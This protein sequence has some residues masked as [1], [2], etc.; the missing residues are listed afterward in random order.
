MLFVFDLPQY[1]HQPVII[2]HHVFVIVFEQNPSVTFVVQDGLG[3][4]RWWFTTD[5]SEELRLRSTIRAA[6]L[7]HHTFCTIH[8]ILSVAH[9]LSGTET[10]CRQRARLPAHQIGRNSCPLSFRYDVMLIIVPQGTIVTYVGVELALLVL[11]AV[12]SFHPNGLFVASSVLKF[13]TAIL[14]ITLSIVDH[15]RSP[16]PSVLLSS[17]LFVTLILDVAQVRTL[18]L[19]AGG[20]SERTYSSLFSASVALKVAM[21]LLEAKPK[22]KWVC[23]DEKSHSPEETSSIFSLSVFF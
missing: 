22:S 23:W 11:V 12:R 3:S 1:L 8:S 17:Y 4:T 13:V 18:F 16:R 21:L 7:L 9:Y 5:E 14:M 20:K 6:V 19:L 2:T 15:S 10:R